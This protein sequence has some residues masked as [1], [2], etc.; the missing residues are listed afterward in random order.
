MSVYVRKIK[1]CIGILKSPNIVDMH[2]VMAMLKLKIN[3]NLS[4][5]LCIV[6]SAAQNG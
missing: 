6:V 3:V 5:L 4:Q 2:R 1:K